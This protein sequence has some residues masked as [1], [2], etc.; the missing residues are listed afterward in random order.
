M[1]CSSSEESVKKY[2]GGH[3]ARRLES[4]G[5][6]LLLSRGAPH[7]QTEGRSPG[8]HDVGGEL[9]SELNIWASRVFFCLSSSFAT[10]FTHTQLV[11]DIDQTAHTMAS[12]PD[13]KIDC[14]KVYVKK[15]SFSNEETGQ[16]DGAFAAVDIKEGR[17]DWECFSLALFVGAGRPSLVSIQSDPLTKILFLQENLLR[18]E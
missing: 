8:R 16:F 13:T 4:G 10:L 7:V 17:C 11:I 9:G 5:Q 12:H 1:R 15:S 14:S 2:S 18:R 3:K 6:T